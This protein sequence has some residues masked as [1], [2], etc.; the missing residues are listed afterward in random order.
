MLER[1]PP[2]EL[3]LLGGVGREL[4][5]RD[6]RVQ[7]EVLHDPDVPGEVGGAALD[8]GHP[9]VDVPAVVLERAHGRDEHGRARPQAA[10]PAGD[11]EELLH[12]HV[13]GEAGLGDQV[14]AELEPDA[15]GD[16]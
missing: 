11:V 5:D 16:E 7:P 12:P 13:G 6:D 9:A 2:D 4:V 10:D 14:L 3:E 8:L 15:V 1:E